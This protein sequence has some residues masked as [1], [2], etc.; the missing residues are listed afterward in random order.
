MG[1]QVPRP[2]HAGKTDVVQIAL[3]GVAQH[4]HAHRRRGRRGERDQC[5]PGLGEQFAG[6]GG[7]LGRKVDQQHAIDARLHRFLGEALVAVDL[8]RVQVAHQHHRR[9]GVGLAELADGLQHIAQAGTAGQRLF[10]TALD[11][12]TVGHRIGER[13][14]EFDDVGSGFHQ[15]VHYR[16]GGLQRRIAR[17][18]EGNERLAIGTA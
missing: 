10:G 4:V 1:V 9:G 5:Q 15:G 12:G 6:F 18:D 13:H 2:G 3:R 11:G 17:G 8:D 16:H 7:F 14:A